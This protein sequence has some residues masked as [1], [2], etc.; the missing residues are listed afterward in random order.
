MIA[1][2]A[3][4]PNHVF[5]N[6]KKEVK[7]VTRYITVKSTLEQSMLIQM[8][9]TNKNVTARPHSGRSGKDLQVMVKF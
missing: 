9:N 2:T 7:S 6:L 8:L 1:F 5:D 4:F 3:T